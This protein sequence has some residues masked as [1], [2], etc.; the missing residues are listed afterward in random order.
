MDSIRASHVA[1]NVGFCDV[2]RN[3]TSYRF[4][5]A[6]WILPVRSAHAGDRIFHADTMVSAGSPQ[7]LV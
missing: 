7:R 1:W 6:N 3:L 5:D 2:H 4:N